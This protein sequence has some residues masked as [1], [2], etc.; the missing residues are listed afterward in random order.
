[1]FGPT[2]FRDIFLVA[3]FELREMRR[4]RRALL[5][6]TLYLIVASLSSYSF[7]QV[8]SVVQPITNMGQSRPTLP[9]LRNAPPPP[10]PASPSTAP[11]QN[12]LFQRG[13]PFRGMLRNSVVDQDAVEFLISMPPMAL[14]YMLISFMFLPL[15]IMLTASESVA[16]EHQTRGTRFIALRTGRAEFVLG[17]VL[18]QG[19]VIGILTLFSAGVA[20]AVAAYKLA[21]FEFLPALSAMLLFW[22]RILAY[23]LAFLGLAGLCSMNSSSTVVSRTFSIVSLVALWILHHLAQ[24]YIAALPEGDTRMYVF[25]TLDFLTPYS[26]QNAMFYPQLSHYGA[27]MAALVFLAAFYIGIGLIFYRRRDL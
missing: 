6:A 2:P 18:G 9:G 16:Q 4:S 26:H 20:M 27:A 3:S 17:K 23:A 24:V 12:K 11:E 10:A 21:D 19:F 13:S 7:A 22:P 8:L 14:F 25:K 15:L 1:M 5:F